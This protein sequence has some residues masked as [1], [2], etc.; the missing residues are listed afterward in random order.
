MSKFIKSIKIPFLNSK[1]HHTLFYKKNDEN[2]I[3]IF[4]LPI[5]PD[6]DSTISL[7]KNSFKNFGGINDNDDCVQITDNYTAILKFKNQK[8]LNRALNQEFKYNNAKPFVSTG[9]CGAAYFKRKYVDSH[10]SIEELKRV[11]DEQIRKYEEKAK[12]TNYVE[13]TEA[14]IQK[15]LDKQQKRLEKMISNDFYQ[16]QQSSVM[17]K[18]FLTDKIEKEPR[19]LKKKPKNKK[20]DQSK[21]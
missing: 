1:N 4:N 8:S 12:N 20:N 19:H 11:S 17:A 16:F 7:I 15:L 3:K 21:T 10:P 2:S 9:E 6:S 18:A 5:C 14:E 13:F